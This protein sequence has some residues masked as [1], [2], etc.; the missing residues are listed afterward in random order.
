M[1][2]EDVEDV[3]IRNEHTPEAFAAEATEGAPVAT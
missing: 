1:T 3:K 2:A